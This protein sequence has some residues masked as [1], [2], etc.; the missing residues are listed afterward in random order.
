[1][2]K[3]VLTQADK[4]IVV[5]AEMKKE[6]LAIQDDC[7]IDIITNGYDSEIA[8]DKHL[9]EKFSILH[10]GSINADRSHESFYKVLAE[11]I[12]G[13]DD[14]EK[15]LQLKLI[16][17]VDI[18]TRDFIAKYNL[19]KFTNFIAYL[20]YREISEIQAKAHLLYLPINNSPNAKGILTGKF[21]EY[22]AAKRPIIA[23]GPS[24][25]DIAKILE[26]TQA[27]EIFDFDD[28]KVIKDYIRQEFD[29]YQNKRNTFASLGIEKY[30]RQNLSKKLDQILGDLLNQ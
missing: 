11:L 26:E 7:N 5:G 2:E 9:D 20:P 30:S 1:L 21:F 18:K 29:H 3:K 15:H 12:E 13:N 22:L 16:G 19:N 23:Q 4:V 17:K 6:F 27:G 10:V 14:F 28:S 24:D 8:K 25:G